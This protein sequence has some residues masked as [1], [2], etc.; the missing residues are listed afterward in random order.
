MWH[1]W[2][3]ENGN[4]RPRQCWIQ[5]LS[6]SNWETGPWLHG[7]GCQ[8]LRRKWKSAASRVISS[9]P[10][11]I[12]CSFKVTIAQTISQHIVNNAGL[13][14]SMIKQ[15]QKMNETHTT[16]Q[17][18][19]L[20]NF[21][22][23]SEILNRNSPRQHVISPTFFEHWILEF[24]GDFPRLTESE[25]LSEHNW[26]TAL[27]NKLQKSN[28]EPDTKRSKMLNSGGV[29]ARPHKFRRIGYRF[30]R[31][32]QDRHTNCASFLPW[33]RKGCFRCCSPHSQLM[34]GMMALFSSCYNHTIS[35]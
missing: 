16:G 33:E 28:L 10:S 24:L 4:S 23:V 12:K 27:N 35:L 6:F 18:P 1:A 20:Q 21:K 31:S 8:F 9:A 2:E 29:H 34:T 15:F 3:S 7:F 5:K 14:N 32:Q 19:S 22:N 26:E 25:N 30:G 11:N 17:M 13:R